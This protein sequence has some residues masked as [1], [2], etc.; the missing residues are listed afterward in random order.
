MNKRFMKHICVGIV[1]LLLSVSCFYASTYSMHDRMND[2]DTDRKTFSGNEEVNGTK[3]FWFN[4]TFEEDKH[5]ERDPTREGLVLIIVATIFLFSSILYLGISLTIFST[6]GFDTDE[7]GF[8]K[9][10]GF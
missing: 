2:W 6:G 5:Y 3:I 4:E 7:K 9:R 8:R 1:M 10:Y